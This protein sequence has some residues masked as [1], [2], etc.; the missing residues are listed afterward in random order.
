MTLGVEEGIVFTLSY[1]C[2]LPLPNLL[3]IP[4]KI[5]MIE[6]IRM[7]LRGVLLPFYR[8]SLKASF[9]KARQ[10]RMKGSDSF[11]D[12]GDSLHV[13]AI[14]SRFCCRPAKDARHLLVDTCD[15]FSRNHSGSIFFFLNFGLYPIW[16][17]ILDQN[18]FLLY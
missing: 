9:V 13:A 2:L 15:G 11:G 17:I 12:H 3:R 16:I 5:A 4:K 8:C 1:P 18:P 7:P 6:V 14:R 10:H